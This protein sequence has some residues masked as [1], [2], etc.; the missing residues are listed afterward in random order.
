MFLFHVYE[1]EVLG[2]KEEDGIQNSGIEGSQG[3]VIVDQG[4]V[5]KFWENYIRE[6]SDQPNWGG[7]IQEVEPEG[8]VD[9]DKKGFYILQS[10]VEK[11][12]KD[13]REKEAT[14]DDDV[15]GDV[16]EMLGEDGVRLPD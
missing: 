13:M 3:N 2:W 8:T 6:L 14:G 12:V 4:K 11:G 1:D 10:E 5:L 7:G 16:L 15:P 9:V